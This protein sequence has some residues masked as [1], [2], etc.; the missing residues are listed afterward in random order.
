M[1]DD[2]L[3]RVLGLRP[4][5]SQEEITRAFRQRARD[6]HPDVAG[7]DSEQ[8]YRRIRDA[9][10]RLTAEGPPPGP[11]PRPGVRI[12][13]RVHGQPPRPGPDVT[14]R[15]RLELADLLSGTTRPV[16]AADGT[17]VPVR[18][19]PGLMPGE[20]LRVAGHGRPGRHGGPPGD[21]IVTVE[22]AEHPR[23]RLHGR[24]LHTD[25][26]ISYPQ[27]V[28]GAEVTL[29]APG[30]G[31]LTI[32]VPAGTTPGALLRLPGRGAPATT[33]H[34]AGDLVV[35]VQLH[36]PARLA[37]QARRAVAALADLL[38]PPQGDQ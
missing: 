24:D 35:T 8:E 19:P 25:L 34:P 22:A 3:Y 4:G 32:G 1:A 7:P 5:A 23:F 26:V 27:A 14:A 37:P 33:R 11:R 36:I 20:R 30:I 10:E 9:Y 6:R 28:L 38:P 15:L 21:L 16:A 29:D 31:T 12:P 2:D 13:V 18:I 17:T